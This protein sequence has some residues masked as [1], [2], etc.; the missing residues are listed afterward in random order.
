MTVET[1]GLCIE[2]PGI[3]S[4]TVL[5]VQTTGL[6]IETSG[7]GIVPVLAVETELCIKTSGI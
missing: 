7:M 4:V 1:K 5:T 3:G 6:Y 2:T